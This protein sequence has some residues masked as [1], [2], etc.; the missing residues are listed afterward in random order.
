MVPLDNGQVLF[1]KGRDEYD[2]VELSRVLE[3]LGFGPFITT[4]AELAEAEIKR[5]LLERGMSSVWQTVIFQEALLPRTPD[6]PAL[7]AIL[8][9]MVERLSPESDFV[10]VDR[11]LFPD[12][13]R[14]SGD[15]LDGLVEVLDPAVRRVKELLVVTSEKHNASLRCALE[16]RL[17][18]LNPGCRFRHCCSE[19]FHDRFW[20]ADRGR[21]LFLGT[22]LNGLGSRYAL[23]DKLAHDDVQ[24]IVAALV[25][26]GLLG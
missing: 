19:N 25:S 23:V 13:K 22:S 3:P 6:V 1:L 26:E 5:I 11:Y 7:V 9:G 21:G 15:Y 17:R 8:K 12:E 18:A 24:E 2:P 10:V 20:I 4:R 16:Q 14:C